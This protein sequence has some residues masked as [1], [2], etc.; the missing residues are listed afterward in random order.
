MVYDTEKLIIHIIRKHPDVW[1][2]SEI[3]FNLMANLIRGNRAAL[4]QRILFE[5][6]SPRIC[7]FLHVPRLY[8][9]GNSTKDS[10]LQIAIECSEGMKNSKFFFFF[11]LKDKFDN[12]L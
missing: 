9:W 4:I 8:D 2:F 6:T 1:K 5:N 12:F 3:R 11:F 7:R 10:D